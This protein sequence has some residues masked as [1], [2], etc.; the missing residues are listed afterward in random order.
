MLMSTSAPEQ[1][2]GPSPQYVDGDLYRRVYDA[3]KF[4]EPYTEDY[5]YTHVALSDEERADRRARIESNEGPVPDFFPESTGIDVQDVQYRISYLG[6]IKRGL[7]TE[8]PEYPRLRRMYAGRITEEQ[9]NLRIVKAAANR[10]SVQ[11]RQA[12][13][14]IYGAPSTALL[15]AVAD[16]LCDEAEEAHRVGDPQ[17]RETSERVLGR[18]HGVRRSS[19]L[20]L[21]DPETYARVR[22]ELWTPESGYLALLMSGVEIPGP[23]TIITAANGDPLDIKMLSNIGGRQVPIDAPYWSI[24]PDILRRPPEYSQP[25]WEHAEF[26][27]HEGGHAEERVNAEQGNNQLATTGYPK[28]EIGNE[29]RGVVIEQVVNNDLDLF[30]KRGRWHE[31]L[32]RAVTG[33]LAYGYAGN[34]QDARSVFKIVRDISRMHCAKA[35]ATIQR[36]CT[37]LTAQ[38][39]SLYTPLSKARTARAA[40]YQRARKFTCAAA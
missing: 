5:V 35:T 21:P 10:D 9:D 37:R 32:G 22:D 18:L 13:E 36:L 28:Y 39:G 6:G 17:L 24:K 1:G 31:L 38:R 27:A 23:N 19:R 7:G 16:F 11:Y 12:N 26:V 40:P 15:G 29:G 4:E 3:A 34:E 8:L 33:A 30:T 14:R 20:L 2:A 25:F